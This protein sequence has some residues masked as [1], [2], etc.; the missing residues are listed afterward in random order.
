MIPRHVEALRKR[1]T[2]QPHQRPLRPSQ[3]E[4]RLRLHHLRQRRI[5]LGLRPHAARPYLRK[6]PRHLDRIKHVLRRQH[7]VHLRLHLR[8]RQ[9][10][11]HLQLDVRLERR[12][13]HER[14]RD[15]IRR[16]RHL[17]ALVHPIHHAVEQQQLPV[18]PLKRPQPEVPVRL[19]FGQRRR[20][21]KMPF[22]QRVDRGPLRHRSAFLRRHR[23]PQTQRHHPQ[24]QGFHPCTLPSP[25]HPP[26][27][28]LFPKPVHALPRLV[29]CAFSEPSLPS[30]PSRD[31]LRPP[32]LTIELP[33]LVSILASTRLR[34]P[35]P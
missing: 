9:P 30:P 26:Q 3:R 6:L 15:R 34:R 13:R 19:H 7:R 10:R 28:H 31:P 27:P 18:Q 14:R 35:H 5:R 22:Q 23:R 29:T 12:H 8:Q 24:Q 16:Q 25:D 17:A 33:P 1:R 20:P 21:V 2:P 32:R 4:Q 11:R